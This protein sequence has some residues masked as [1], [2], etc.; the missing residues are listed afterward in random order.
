MGDSQ[1]YEALRKKLR[2]AA[3]PMWEELFAD[4]PDDGLR[5]EALH[6]AK[7]VP[8][9]SELAV[10]RILATFA[11]QENNLRLEVCDRPE[12]EQLRRLCEKIT[13]DLETLLKYFHPDRPSEIL[14]TLA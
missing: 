14:A 4:C 10:R 13:S 9:P 11:R 3:V 1:V 7:G 5:E 12:G 8:P 2:K 6:A